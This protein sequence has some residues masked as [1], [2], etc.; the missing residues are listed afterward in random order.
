MFISLYRNQ[1]PEKARHLVV[2]IRYFSIVCNHGKMCFYLYLVQTL[3]TY[4]LNTT[5][6]QKKDKTNKQTKPKPKHTYLLCD[7]EISSDF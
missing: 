3:A 2:F 7:K 6:K 5:N 1:K 4:L